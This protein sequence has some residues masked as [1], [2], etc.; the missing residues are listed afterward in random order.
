MEKA[1]ERDETRQIAE[2][3]QTRTKNEPDGTAHEIDD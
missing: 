2:K 3:G 1:R